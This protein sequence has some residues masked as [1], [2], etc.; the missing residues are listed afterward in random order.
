MTVIEADGEN[1]E[2]L[3]VDSLQIFAGQRYS[4]I[5]EARQAVGSYWIRADPD[6]SFGKPGFDG[7][8]NS[9]I[10]RYTGAAFADPIAAQTPSQRPLREI[11]LHPLQNAAAP[12]KPFVGGADVNINFVVNVD[13]QTSK[14]TMNGASYIPPSVPVLLQI[15]NGARTGWDMLPAGSIYELPRNKVVELSLPGTGPDIGG[16]VSCYYLPLVSCTMLT[17]AHR[18]IRSIFMG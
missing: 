3:V 8:R 4:A 15:L 13:P 7:G 6:A 11:D 2:P 1:T 9:A 17:S 5:V 12:G 18:S 16:P 10:L 14:F